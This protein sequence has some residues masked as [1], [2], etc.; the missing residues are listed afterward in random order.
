M[1]SGTGSQKKAFG[2]E[3]GDESCAGGEEPVAQEK[4][5]EKAPDVCGHRAPKLSGN[6]AFS[7]YLR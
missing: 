7:T 5:K 1:A 2:H 6:D 4:W 3:E